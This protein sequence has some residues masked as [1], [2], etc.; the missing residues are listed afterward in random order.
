MELTWLS[1]WRQVKARRRE[2]ASHQ[3]WVL[4]LIGSGIWVALQRAY[5]IV[6][7][8]ST[9]AQM[10]ANFGDGEGSAIQPETCLGQLMTS[11]SAVASR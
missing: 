2:F 4:R 6:R 3:R 7:A 1:R 11:P 9:P 5:V 10:K 8:G